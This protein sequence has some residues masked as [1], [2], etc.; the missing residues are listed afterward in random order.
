MTRTSEQ[1]DSV[2][3]ADSLFQMYNVE[4][5]FYLIFHQYSLKKIISGKKVFQSDTVEPLK[6]LKNLN[7]LLF[8]YL[9]KKLL[10]HNN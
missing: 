6:L 2:Y 9:H 10:C 8:S 7:D 5:K 1:G 4:N 3:K